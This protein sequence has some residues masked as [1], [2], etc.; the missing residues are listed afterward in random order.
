MADLRAA[1]AKLSLFQYQKIPCKIAH[2]GQV[3]TFFDGG[4]NVHLVTEEFVRRAKLPRRP[5]FQSMVTTGA[6]AS[7]W[8]T[9]AYNVPLVDR[10]NKVHTILA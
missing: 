1:D 6:K 7:D 4:S 8:H 5:V 3:N 9:V 10:W 2:I